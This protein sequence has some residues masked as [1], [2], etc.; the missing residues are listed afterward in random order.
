MAILGQIMANANSSSSVVLDHGVSNKERQ[1]SHCRYSHGG[2]PICRRMFQFLH[3]VGKTKLISSFKEHGLTSRIHGNKKRLPHNAL[4]LS[5]VEYFVKLLLNYADQNDSSARSY[6]CYCSSIQQEKSA[7]IKEAQDH[8][9]LV[10]LKRSFYKTTCDSCR[11]IIFVL[12][13][14]FLLLLLTVT[15]LRIQTTW[16]PIIL[17]I[18]HNK[19]ITLPIRYSQVQLFF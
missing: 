3:I 15:F 7:T 5:S 1:R 11:Q 17:L 4:F 18:M 8:L 10:Q 2:Q 14:Y 13:A 6:P 9:M 19:C 16:H 12:M